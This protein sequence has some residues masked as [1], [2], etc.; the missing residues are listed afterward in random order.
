[1]GS[2]P[3]G[4]TV[5]AKHEQARDQQTCGHGLI[6]FVQRSTA[7]TGLLR[8]AV[9]PACPGLLWSIG[10]MHITH[11]ETAAGVSQHKINKSRRDSSL[12]AGKLVVMSALM[13]SIGRPR[14]DFRGMIFYRA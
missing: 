13:G 6:C 7:V 1:M 5:S 12:P 10:V 14:R 11:R 9:P 8:R 2:S 4:G 3:T